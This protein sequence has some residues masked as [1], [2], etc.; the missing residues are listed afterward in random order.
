MKFCCNPNTTTVAIYLLFI[1][2]WMVLFIKTSKQDK[3]T[4][5]LDDNVKDLLITQDVVQA[6]LENN[7]NMEILKLKYS[8][9]T[10]QKIFN[11]NENAWAIITDEG[12]VI[13]GGDDRDGGDS[14]HVQL[15]LKNVKMM[16]SSLS[17]FLALLSNGSVIAWGEESCGGKISQKL[18]KHHEPCCFS[19]SC[20]KPIQTQLQNIKMI[21]SSYTAF[22]TLLE[23]GSVVAWGDEN[24]GGKITDEMQFKLKN[25]TKI[26]STNFAFAALTDDGSV[27]TWPKR[28]DRDDIQIH[29]QQ[30][31]INIFST[32]L[33][34]TALLKDGSIIT[35]EYYG[36]K[37]S[38]EIQ[39]QLNQNV[40]TIFSNDAAFIALLK[41]GNFIA[42]GLERYG[43]GKI[44]E[45]MQDKL[46][47]TKIIYSSSMAFA[48]ILENGSIF[49]WGHEDG[50]GKIPDEIQYK[51][52]ENVK[53]IFPQEFGFIAVCYN[54]EEIYW[55]RNGY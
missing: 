9:Y 25:I 54:N 8:Q 55:G 20:R 31:V 34:F 33:A 46:K 15:Q 41:N 3:I 22:A 47:N 5:D 11:K 30:N 17:A 35:W 26:F 50:G 27:F 38:D 13:T 32:N 7:Q 28:K 45:E 53:L 12:D 40:Q 19:F 2:L 10:D 48:A 14:R 1:L 37:I 18:Y 51:L 16:V 36:D 6:L 4:F 42:W 43:G 24:F 49:T 39:I 21:V 52:I 29:L 44:T 23:D